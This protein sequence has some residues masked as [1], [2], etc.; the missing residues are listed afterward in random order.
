MPQGI[1]VV[2]V[3][4]DVGADRLS[5]NLKASLVCMTTRLE[6][7]YLFTDQQLEQSASLPSTSTLT[8]KSNDAQSNKKCSVLAFCVVSL[9]LNQFLDFR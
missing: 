2:D 6:S 8:L 4:V 1:Q 3:A 5:L 9:R 7:I